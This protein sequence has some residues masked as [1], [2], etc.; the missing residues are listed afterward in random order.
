MVL[1]VQ[2]LVS[3]LTMQRPKKSS[4]TSL[5]KEKLN[6]L[7]NQWISCTYR[8]TEVIGQTA[9]P[10][11]I[12][13]QIQRITD[14]TSYLAEALRVTDLRNTWMVS[15][16]GG[17]TWIYRKMRNSWGQGKG[18]Y[19][20][21][22]LI[23]GFYL[24]PMEWGKG[25]YLRSHLK[26]TVLEHSSSTRWNLII[27]LKECFLCT[28]PLHQEGSSIIVSEDYGYERAARLYLIN[29]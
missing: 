19:L 10:K 11:L 8:K 6:N 3:V 12:D 2:L 18:N 29:S 27:R 21:I 7:K 23:L 14:E 24:I 25:K 17:W 15:L 20:K 5:Q 9:T 16:N 26:I 28:L 4:M 22:Q 13:R 1:K